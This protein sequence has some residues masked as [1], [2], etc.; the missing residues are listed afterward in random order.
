MTDI[1]EVIIL[2]LEAEQSE[3][4]KQLHL[5][6][7]VLMTLDLNI[8]YYDDVTVITLNLFNGLSTFLYWSWKNWVLLR[9]RVLLEYT[10][11]EVV[12]DKHTLVLFV[13]HWW[14]AGCRG[15]LGV[16]R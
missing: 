3:I 12:Q 8:F 11:D 5:K 10:F 2:S 9:V 7:P 14:E 16:R 4:W 15:V 6:D 13:I 1:E